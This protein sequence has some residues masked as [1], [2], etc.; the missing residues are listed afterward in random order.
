[1]NCKKKNNFPLE[2]HKKNTFVCLKNN[3]FAFKTTSNSGMQV[4]DLCLNKI[5]SVDKILF[6]SIKIKKSFEKEKKKNIKKKA[7]IKKQKVEKT[8]GKIT[9]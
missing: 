6:S 9:Y 8:K 2:N 1:M 5:S 7:M 4:Q 3:S